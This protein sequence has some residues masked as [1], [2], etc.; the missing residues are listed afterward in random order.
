MRLSIRIPVF[1]VGLGMVA[2]IALGLAAFYSEKATLVREAEL[3]LL[4]VLDGRVSELDSYLQSIRDDLVVIAA[5]PMV[6]TGLPAFAEAWNAIPGDKTATLQKLYIT[7][8]PNPTGKKEELD[9]AQDGSA[10]SQVHADHHPW[11]RQFLRTRDY[12]DIFFFNPD[13][14]L[15]YTVFKELDYATNLKTGTWAQ[16]DLGNVF[17]KSLTLSKGEVAFFDFRPYAPSHDAPASFMG[18][19]VVTPEGKTIGVLVFQMPIAKLNAL[20]QRT[21]GL[22]E[23]GETFVV[24]TDNLMRSDSRFSSESTILKREIKTEHVRK[25][26]AG[27]HGVGLFQGYDGRPVAAAYAGLDF[28]GVRWAV[29]AVQDESE[30]LAPVHEQAVLMSIQVVISALVL[31]V[32][33][34]LLSRSITRPIS[35]LNGIMFRLSDHDYGVEVPHQGRKDELGDIARAT[36]ILRRA[37]QEAVSLREQ[38]ELDRQ[39]AE[40][41]KSNA[42]KTMAETVESETRKAVNEVANQSTMVSRTSGEMASS[43]TR[44]SDNATGVAAAAEEALVN[45]QAVAAATEEMTAAIGEIS[46]QVSLAT[47]VTGRAVEAGERTRSTIDRL[48]QAV[49]RIGEV[50]GLIADIASQT[51]LLALNATIEAARAGDAGK[52]FAVVANEVKALANQTGRST[53]EISR[54][55][56]DIVAVT[57]DAV[58]AV[59]T[60]DVT[61][62]E[63]DQVSETIAAAMEEQQASTSEISRNVSQTAEAAR[64]VARRIEDVSQEAG[65][66]R[67]KAA[68][69]QQ[70]ADGVSD[71]IDSLRRIL[72]AVVRTAT[73][74]V[75]RRTAKRETVTL[76]AR[77]TDSK[78]ETTG[79]LININMSGARLAQLARP[80]A[81][82]GTVT[83]RIAGSDPV[84]ARVITA[85][86]NEASI[87]FADTSGNKQI[88]GKLVRGR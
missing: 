45:A 53:E 4:A 68:D 11:L 50:A 19:P 18:T 12:Y 47:Q 43:A 61:I 40:V 72:V 32:A 38:Q 33:G 30:T 29:V 67:Q 63:M 85:E 2:V 83:L 74:D 25:A 82:T 81:S 62:R 49:D 42:L 55:I 34:L 9:A 37:G 31:L 21:E 14:D 65:A 77:I 73:D 60:I 10:Y 16:T 78:G 8:N 71:A 5:S 26:L 36:E 58:E 28:A 57:M 15:V 39:A 86:D 79:T 59:D 70:A 23:T 46:Q 27:E 24:G 75:D 48:R 87:A 84:D 41:Q 3:K 76:N 44:M 7:D 35:Q 1:I 20:M 88:I 66:N 69:M 80:L 22:G 17:R 52:G 13:G 64:E 6:Q 51:N 54:Q 56:A